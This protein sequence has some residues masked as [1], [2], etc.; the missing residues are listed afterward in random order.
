V[1]CTGEV[2]R[3]KVY[4]FFYFLNLSSL[5]SLLTLLGGG[6]GQTSRTEQDRAGS[7]EGHGDHKTEFNFFEHNPRQN[8]IRRD[9]FRRDILS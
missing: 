5:I 4:V 6:G 1:Y 9:K 3:S 7:R 2:N 8:F